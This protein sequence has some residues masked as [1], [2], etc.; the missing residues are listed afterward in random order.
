MTRKHLKAELQ[1]EIQKASH[2]AITSMDCTNIRHT[3]EW[4]T[5]FTELKHA[6]HIRVAFMSSTEHNKAGQAMTPVTRY[7]FS[8]QE[9]IILTDFDYSTWS[10]PGTHTEVNIRIHN[11]QGESCIYV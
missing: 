3:V 8:L 1:S 4:V 2:L 7:L 5:S 11:A 10:C 9:H 6:A